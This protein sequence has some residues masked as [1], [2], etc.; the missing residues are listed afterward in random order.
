MRKFSLPSSLSELVLL[1]TGLGRLLGTYGDSNT[2]AKSTLCG[3]KNIKTVKIFTRVILI[4]KH[5]ASYNGNQL[6]VQRN[7]LSFPRKLYL[8]F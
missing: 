1:P 2:S 4:L 8:L 6:T 5:C 3:C 7:I